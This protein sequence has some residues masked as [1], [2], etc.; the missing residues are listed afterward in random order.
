MEDVGDGEAMG[1]WIGKG[2]VEGP[3]LVGSRSWSGRGPL[4]LVL[5]LGLKGFEEMSVD[6]DVDVDVD[7]VWSNERRL[8]ALLGLSASETLIVG[9]LE[10][11]VV[12]GEAKVVQVQG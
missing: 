7:V 2:A 5:E 11:V 6:I 9:S 10:G 3:G 4:V 1:E 12:M 8:G